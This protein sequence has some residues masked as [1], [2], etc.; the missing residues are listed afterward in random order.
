MEGIPGKQPQTPGGRSQWRNYLFVLAIVFLLAL[1]VAVYWLWQGGFTTRQTAPTTTLPSP[2]VSP[3]P[4]RSGPFVDIT[5]P[6]DGAVLDSGQQIT[7]EGFGGALFEGNVVIEVRDLSGNV[8]AQTATIIQSPEAGTGGQG[9]WQVQMAVPVEPGSQVAIVAYATSP[10]DGSVVTEDR[11]TVTLGDNGQ[12]STQL[13]GQAWELQTIRG[14]PVLAGTRPTLQF[15][16]DGVGGH[17]GCNAYGGDYT[18]AGNVLEIKDLFS[19][20]MFCT[21]PAG[22]TDQEAAFLHALSEVR[23]FRL[24]AGRLILEDAQGAALLEFTASP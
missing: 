11:V 24:E 15:S 12:N 7:V 4:E 1:A 2:A 8:L 18:L 14:A 6:L 9:P 21:D 23:A 20:M 17:G 22:V 19:T 13:I 10:R 16:A 5:S 3:T